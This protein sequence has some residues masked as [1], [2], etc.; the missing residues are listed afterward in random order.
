LIE[1]DVIGSPPSSS[2]ADQV[3]VIPSVTALVVGASGVAGTYFG[4]TAPLTLLS[5]L[6]EEPISFVAC[7]LA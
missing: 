7:T 3:I 2:G 6:L 1:Y 4:I 5:D